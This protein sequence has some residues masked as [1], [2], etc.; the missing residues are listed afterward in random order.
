MKWNYQLADHAYTGKD[1]L[2]Y[3][4]DELVLAIDIDDPVS[5]ITTGRLEV[6][7]DRT[8]EAPLKGD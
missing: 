1:Q 4:P 6:I 5:T 3:R 8:N 2:R 7:P